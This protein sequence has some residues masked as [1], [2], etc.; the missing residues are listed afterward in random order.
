M[1]EN[2]SYKMICWPSP[3]PH[4]VI[5]VV[6]SWCY[7]GIISNQKNP[8]LCVFNYTQLCGNSR[9]VHSLILPFQDASDLLSLRPHSAVVCRITFEGLLWRVTWPKQASFRCFTNHKSGYWWFGDATTWSLTQTFVLCSQYNM[10]R[11][12]LKHLYST[13]CLCSQ[14]PTLAPI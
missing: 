7:T 13:L 14:S 10:C 11:I 8:P 3:L 6:N 5:P 1:S 2:N 9:P 4:S 12:A